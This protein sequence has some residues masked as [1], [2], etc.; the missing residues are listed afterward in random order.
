VRKHHAHA[1]L[2]RGLRMLGRDQ[3]APGTGIQG[4]ERMLAA[5]RALP[6][7]PDEQVAGASAARVDHHAPGPRLDRAS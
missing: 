3:H 4:L 5:V 6:P 2:C 7:Q 1:G